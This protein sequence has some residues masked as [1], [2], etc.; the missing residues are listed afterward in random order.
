MATQANPVNKVLSEMRTNRTLEENKWLVTPIKKASR[1][2]T[3][4]LATTENY[5]E[6]ARIESAKSVLESIKEIDKDDWELIKH[7]L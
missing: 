5:S 6:M 7:F 4:I 3:N 1:T 2:V